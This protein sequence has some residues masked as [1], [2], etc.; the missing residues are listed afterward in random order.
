MPMNLGSG[1]AT[2]TTPEAE[3]EVDPET[4]DDNDLR[5]EIRV[6]IR[7]LENRIIL[8]LVRSILN[9]SLEADTIPL[10]N[11]GEAQNGVLHQPVM[12]I[13]GRKRTVLATLVKKKTE[14]LNLMLVRPAFHLAN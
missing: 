11:K 9:G 8:A 14:I 3:T 13:R 7:F 5:L 4:V 12:I 1:V 6:M 2:A 10:T